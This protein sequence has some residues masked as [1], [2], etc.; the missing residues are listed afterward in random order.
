LALCPC[1]EARPETL[2]AIALGLLPGD[3]VA[4]ASREAGFSALFPADPHAWPD[5]LPA[6]D[7]RLWAGQ[8]ALAGGVPRAGLEAWSDLWL[9]RFAARLQGLQTS[10]RGYLQREFLCRPGRIELSGPEAPIRIVLPAF[11]LGI[12]LRMSGLTGL[13]PPVP[14]LGARRLLIDLER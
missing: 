1:P 5:P 4:V 2:R 12:V 10:S 13:T 14:H 11:P 9:A 6:P 8:G 7:A 3:A